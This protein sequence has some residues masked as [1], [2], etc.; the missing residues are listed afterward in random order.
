MNE[1]A[2]AA[3]IEEVVL[4]A[5]PRAVREAR[6]LTARLCELAGLVGDVVDTAV[7]LTSEVVTN[8][9]I[10]GRSEARLVVSVRPSEVLVEVGDDNSRRPVMQPQDEDALDGRG[11]GLLQVA[12]SEWGVR[13]APVGK[14]VWFVVRAA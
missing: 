4:A 8:A 3:L 1:T 6:R 7:L 10:H 9:V 14:V 2:P 5:D 11:V 13:E 12:A